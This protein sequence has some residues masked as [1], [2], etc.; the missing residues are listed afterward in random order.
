[1][2]KKNID[3]SIPRGVII[4]HRK[5]IYTQMMTGD[6]VCSSLFMKI[7]GDFSDAIFSYLDVWQKKIGTEHMIYYWMEHCK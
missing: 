1:M 6:S 3:N 7:Y 5:N 2:N 4:I